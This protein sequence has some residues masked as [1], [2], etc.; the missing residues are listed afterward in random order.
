M[1]IVEVIVLICPNVFELQPV[2]VQIAQ[3][4]KRLTKMKHKMN[5]KLLN[6]QNIGT[7]SMNATPFLFIP[8][9]VLNEI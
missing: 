1:F 6:C 3:F 2:I 4:K 8:C 9:L 5:N 7:S